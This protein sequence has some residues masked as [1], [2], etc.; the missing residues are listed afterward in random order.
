MLLGAS[1]HWEPYGNGFRTLVLNLATSWQIR[2]INDNGTFTNL[3]TVIIQT[4]HPYL[5]KFP[6]SMTPM[7]FLPCS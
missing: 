5:G 7:L 3:D 6:L 4:M 1:G 2:T